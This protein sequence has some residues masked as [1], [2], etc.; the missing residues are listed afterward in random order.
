MSDATSDDQIESKNQTARSHKT[1]YESSYAESSSIDDDL[2]LV[3]IIQVLKSYE[4]NFK[5]ADA[6]DGIEFFAN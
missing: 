1:K 6:A 5:R 2:P 4:L 3:E